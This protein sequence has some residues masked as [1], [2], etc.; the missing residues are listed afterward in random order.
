[1]GSY[2]PNKVER[3][4][5]TR[6]VEEMEEKAEMLRSYGFNVSV[7]VHCGF[8]LVHWSFPKPYLVKSA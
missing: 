8:F 3:I 4:E 5:A 1:M 6:D 7:E 2:L